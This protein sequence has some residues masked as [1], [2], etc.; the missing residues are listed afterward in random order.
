MFWTPDTASWRPASGCGQGGAPR[1]YSRGDT[2][3]PAVADVQSGAPVFVVG[4]PKGWEGRTFHE[5]AQMPR[6]S[7]V[8]RFRWRPPGV[9]AAAAVGVARTLEPVSVVE[10]LGLAY[11]HVLG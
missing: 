7:R 11:S 9:G 5:D 4:L 3:R 10:A 8:M 2:D 6:R 1:A